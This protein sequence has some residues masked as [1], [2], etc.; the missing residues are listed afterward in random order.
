MI[1][2]SLPFAC[3]LLFA[4][5]L[6]HAPLSAQ[7]TQR[8]ILLEEFSTAQCGFCPDGDIVA[9][10]IEKDHPS[11]IWVTHHA[12]FGT[13]SMTAP[14]SNTIAGAFVNFAPSGVIDRVLYPKHVAPYENL[15]TIRGKWDSLVTAHLDDEQY[16]DIRI[17]ST[18]REGTAELE[19]TVEIEFSALP[20]PGDLRVHLYVIEDS[21]IGHGKGYDQTNYFNSTQGHPFR[22]AGDPIVG[23]AHHRVVSAIPGGAWGVTGVIPSTPETGKVYTWNW[24]GDMNAIWDKSNVGRHDIIS[25]VAFVGYHDAD[26]FRRLVV[27]ASE[28]EITNV[29]LATD[30]VLAAPTALNLAVWPSPAA[31]NVTISASLAPS[32]SG[33]LV[34]TDAAG[35]FVVN[36]RITGDNPRY[37]LST[38]GLPDGIYFCRLLSGAGIVSGK[39]LVL[40]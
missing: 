23:Y 39:F 37:S 24:K 29:V 15:G 34:V 3:V 13:D 17:N 11:V 32:S 16:A 33:T 12:G 22:G 40:H 18:Y 4:S 14:G 21:I 30:Q 19:C 35:R 31:N 1:R 10:R 28:A 38:T 26:P 20:A 25:L 7:T 5:L 8:H 9:S 6:A 27:H 2:N 36:T